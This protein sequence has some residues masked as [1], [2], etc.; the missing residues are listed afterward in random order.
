MKTPDEIKRGLA[1]CLSIFKDD[2][3]TRKYNERILDVL[4]YIKQLE[5]ERDAA[6]KDM[7]EA[8]GCL[9]LICKSFVPAQS[10]A[11][12]YTCKAFGN[13]VFESEPLICGQ[14]EWRGVE[15]DKDEA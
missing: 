5:R 3:A 14:F 6:V 12:K 13:H 15:E 11:K 1:C 10:G 8:Q 4:A 9:C 7:H 2:Q